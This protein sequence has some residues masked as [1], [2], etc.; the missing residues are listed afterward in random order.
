MMQ[1]AV[2][3]IRRRTQN[4]KCHKK[5]DPMAKAHGDGSTTGFYFLK[6]FWITETN[7]IQLGGLEE[8]NGG[9]RQIVREGISLWKGNRKG[10]AC[11]YSLEFNIVPTS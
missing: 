2:V 7:D 6:R 5:R 4:R 10:R 9:R 8:L 3:A 11:L 1:T